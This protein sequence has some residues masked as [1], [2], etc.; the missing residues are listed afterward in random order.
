MRVF[1][2]GKSVLAIGPRNVHFDLYLQGPESIV[3]RG[4]LEKPIYPYQYNV[5]GMLNMAITM[6]KVPGPVAEM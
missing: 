3:G 4:I 2:N 6:T 1:V 5:D